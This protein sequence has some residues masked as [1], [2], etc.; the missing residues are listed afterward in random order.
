MFDYIDAVAACRCLRLIFDAAPRYVSSADAAAQRSRLP[1][2]DF[3]VF[4]ALPA[5][6]DLRK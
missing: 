6:S 3:S 4:A 2:F 5:C 1:S